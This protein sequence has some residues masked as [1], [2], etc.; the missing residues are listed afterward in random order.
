M[1]GTVRS[2]DDLA[3]L[4]ADNTS[5]AIVPQTHRDLIESL[6]PSVG[7]LNLSDNPTETEILNSD[8]WTD[9]EIPGAAL[10]GPRGIELDGIGRIKYVDSPPR[11]FSV[12]VSMAISVAQ[13]NQDI[14]IAVSL[15]GA[16]NLNSRV[17]ELMI[18]A[19][20]KRNVTI[21]LPVVAESEDILWCMVNNTKSSSNMTVHRIQI[22]LI[23]FMI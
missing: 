11:L 6:I 12:V 1:A 8:V 10:S 23:G 9:I 7:L 18:K 19:N 5:K 22:Q 21:F 16:E 20:E 3:A 4:Y 13:P 14:S 15:N 2:S 17:D